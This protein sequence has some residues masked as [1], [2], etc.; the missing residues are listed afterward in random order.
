MSKKKKKE[1]IG[2]EEDWKQF[3]AE[4][5]YADSI[6]RLALGDSEE[7]IGSLERAF[8]LMP[9]YAPAIL[10]MGSVEYQRGRATEGKK[11]LLSLLTLPDNTQDLCEIID[12]AGS[13]LIDI[14]AY[15]DGLE[16][17]RGAVA[18]F[19]DVAVIHQGLGC[20]TGHEGL[21]EEAIGASQRALELEP[22]NQKFVNDLGWSLLEAGKLTEAKRTLERAVEM[23]P[24]DELARENLRY[25]NSLIAESTGDPTIA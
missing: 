17:Y 1:K 8:E 13:F 5:A 7:S 20:C 19:P 10:S 2:T 3:H 11:L 12:K 23:D 24:S 22:E 14:G 18:R 4:A 25:C 15:G 6:F 21:H 16:L 9:T